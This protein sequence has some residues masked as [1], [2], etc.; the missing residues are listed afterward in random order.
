MHP[1]ASGLI[2]NLLNVISAIVQDESC[3]SRE[4]RQNAVASQTEGLELLV[5][6]V[7]QHPF[8][9]LIQQNGICAFGSLAE[10]NEEV[11]SKLQKLGAAQI[12]DVAMKEFPDVEQLQ[13]HGSWAL[14]L[15]QVSQKPVSTWF[16]ST[17]R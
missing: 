3:K 16:G 14:R 12:I 10:G 1:L 4:I 8:E 7:M 2:A 15:L 17:R 6:A 11:R 13:A 9:A 5:R